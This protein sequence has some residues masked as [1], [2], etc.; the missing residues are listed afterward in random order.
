MAPMVEGCREGEKKRREGGSFR[1]SVSWK[2]G[3]KGTV[4]VSE[5]LGPQVAGPMPRDASCWLSPAAAAAPDGTPW[6]KD[7][8]RQEKKPRDE[9]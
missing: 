2:R 8:T 5:T 6:L 7:K 1:V 9:E 3:K 4:P